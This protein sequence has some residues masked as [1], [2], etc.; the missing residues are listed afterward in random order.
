MRMV[1]VEAAYTSL[2]ADYSVHE[3][4]VGST[5]GRHPLEVMSISNPGLE[6]AASRGIE[7]R[8]VA[9][10][11]PAS[12]KLVRQVKLVKLLPAA[13]KNA[14]GVARE[15]QP[16]VIYSSQQR[17][18]SFLASII[19]RQLRV[20]LVIHLHY[21]FG[22][23]IGRIAQRTVRRADHV[24]AVS[25][26]I[27]ESTLLRGLADEQ[28]STVHFPTTPLPDADSQRAATRQE[29]GIPQDALV[30][31]AVGRLDPNKGIQHVL[32]VLPKIL[33]DVPHVRLLVCGHSVHAPGFDKQL[34]D[35]AA[36]LGLNEHVSFLGHR[37]D[38]PALMGAADVFCLPTEMDAYPLV[39][40]EA[41]RCG[42]PIVAARSGGVPEAVADGVNGLLSLPGD[43]DALETNLR[44]VLVD[45]Q[46]RVSMREASHR[47][48]REHFDPAQTGDRWFSIIES[49]V[50][51]RRSR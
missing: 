8:Y 2:G 26:F 36:S 43:L 41:M 7:R 19:S 47:R 31:I 11:A 48:L 14:I 42:L 39:F 5:V 44:R 32:T 40:P 15:F 33:P 22:P 34:M 35:Q 28:V 20:P 45:E 46:L 17:R 12:S 13:V 16:D 23:W 9:T 24:I 6:G 10:S 49:V 30:V 51:A 50:E 21:P 38:V 29:L 1:M 3:Q 25:E 4:F 18:D 37:P 27:R